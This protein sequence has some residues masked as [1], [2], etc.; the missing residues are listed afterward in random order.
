MSYI[1]TNSRISGSD[2]IWL[3]QKAL[4]ELFQITLFF[5]GRCNLATEQDDEHSK[6]S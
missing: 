5:E 3:I 2:F 1:D 6:P 4:H